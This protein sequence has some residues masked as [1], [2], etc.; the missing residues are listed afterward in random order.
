MRIY[1]TIVATV[2]LIIV[3]AHR[4]AVGT[5]FIRDGIA[6]CSIADTPNECLNW[7]AGDPLTRTQLEFRREDLEYARN[8]AK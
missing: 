3:G 2:L 5:A 8:L 4:L 6:A 7:L 1:W